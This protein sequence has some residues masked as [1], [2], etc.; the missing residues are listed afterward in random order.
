MR[1]PGR[2]GGR[3]L[4]RPCHRRAGR[5]DGPP[6]LPPAGRP[7]ARAALRSAVDPVLRRRARAL[8]RLTARASDSTAGPAASSSDGPPPGWA[9]GGAHGR[10]VAPSHA[11]ARDR[12]RPRGSPRTVGLH[13]ARAAATPDARP[14]SAAV[15]AT[16]GRA[17]SPPDARSRRCSGGRAADG[18]VLRPAPRPTRRKFT[19][20]HRH[21]TDHHRTI[22]GTTPT[23]VAGVLSVC[24]AES[25]PRFRAGFPPHVR[26]CARGTV[27]LAVLDLDR[28][29]G[30]RR[31]LGFERGTSRPSGPDPRTRPSC[32]PRTLPGRGHADAAGRSVGAARGATSGPHRGTGAAPAVAA[33]R[34][35]WRAPGGS[36]PT[37]EGVAPGRGRPRLV[38]GARRPRPARGCPRRGRVAQT[39][40]AVRRD[41]RRRSRAP[42]RRVARG[43]PTGVTGVLPRSA[44][45]AGSPRPAVAGRAIAP[46][47]WDVSGVGEGWCSDRG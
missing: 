25:P 47:V 31:V 10:P 17:P 30:R 37:I 8:P 23:T 2:R 15:N 33:R 24:R 1:S 7:V 44:S 29:G 40:H 21:L 13:A 39:A 22:T 45:E 6:H 20:R 3:A 4:A 26:R 36:G 38:A 43:G 11:R 12:S 32:D 14:P 41:D 34:L 5:A 16:P 9:T 42:D 27:R 46:V 28:R 35:R 18:S 19:H